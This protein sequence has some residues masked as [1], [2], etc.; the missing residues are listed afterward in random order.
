MRADLTK[1]RQI[2]FNV[3]SNAC[4]FTE[5]GAVSLDVARRQEAG[6]EVVVFKVSDTGIGMTGEQMEILFQPFTQADASISRQFGGTG[7]G[8][9]ITRKFCEIMG[10]SIEV[11]SE[12]GRGSA[13]TIRLP[14]EVASARMKPGG[15][16]EVSDTAS[17]EMS[18]TVLVID[19]DPAVRDLMKRFLVKEGFRVETAPDGEEGLRRARQLRPDAITLDVMMPKMDGWEVLVALKADPELADIPVVMLTVADNRNIG[20]AL[21]A[22]DYITKPIDRERLVRIL[23]RFR[24]GADSFSVLIVDDD[25]SMREVTRRVLEKEGWVVSEAENGRA[26]LDLLDEFRP[27]LIIL[28][29]IMPEMDGFEFIE[30]LHMRPEWRSIPVVVST[31]KDITLEDH[32]RLQGYVEKILE[33]GV[34]SLDE[35]VE[36][37]RD[38]MESSVRGKIES[39]PKRG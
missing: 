18:N 28:D 1:L 36:E 20:F 5:R 21:G 37:V 32:E 14:A 10:G 26:A 22:A 11:E 6:E 4:K 38:L 3:L 35:M 29:L 34:H 30:E 33:K 2:L 15:G 7:L 27:S 13:F 8:L 17:P 12:P 23:G 16:V 31:A 9:T 39:A 19:D 25:R 24:R